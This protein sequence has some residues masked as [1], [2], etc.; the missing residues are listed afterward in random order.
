MHLPRVLAITGVIALLISASPSALAATDGGA[1]SAAKWTATKAPLPANADHTYAQLNSV[2]CPSTSKCIAIGDYTGSAGMQGLLLTKSSSG[3]A[4][5][6]APLPAGAA[7]DPYVSLN[8]IN[9]FSASVCAALGSYTDSSGNTQSLLLTTSGSSWKAA[10]APIPSD[11]SGSPDGS[12]SAVHCSSATSCLAAGSYY[13]SAGD[14]EGLLISGFG[15]TWTAAQAPVPSGA[16][17]NP[18]TQPEAVTCTGSTGGCVVVGT[19]DT[20]NGSAGLLLTGSGSSWTATEAPLPANARGTYPDPDLT[21]VRCLSPSSCTAAGGYY[22]TSYDRYGLLVTGSGTSWAA[23][24]APQPPNANKT[25]PDSWLSSVTCPGPTACVA[26]GGYYTTGGVDAAML[27]TVSTSSLAVSQASLPG[28]AA[29]YSDPELGAVACASASACVATGEYRIATN[30]ERGLLV[31]GGGSSW[32]A[33]QA[34]VPNN[35]GVN[36]DIPAV[37]CPKK[38]STCIAVGY[39]AKSGNDQGLLLSGPA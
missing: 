26:P 22:D 27:V 4:A 13:D 20:S 2:A 10:K 24:Q 21:A 3:W 15:K 32:T 23:T 7:A 9:C 25:S 14:W 16:E 35:T 19:Y 6:E 37:S 30:H 28:N 17:A 39:Y 11:P 5:A 1:A 12:L 36:T 8:S 31:Y 34:P 38:A 33:V 29:K 18:Y